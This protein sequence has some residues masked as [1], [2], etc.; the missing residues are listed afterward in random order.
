MFSAFQNNWS[1]E[2]WKTIGKQFNGLK[3]ESPVVDLDENDGEMTLWFSASFKVTVKGSFVTG[4]DAKGKDIVYS[5]SGSTVL[6]GPSV[7]SDGAV[8]VR[9]FIYF[10]PKAGKFEGYGAEIPLVWDGAAFSVAAD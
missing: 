6:A 7:E 2:P 5:V 3:F 1:K 10:P 8:R 9:A 4:K